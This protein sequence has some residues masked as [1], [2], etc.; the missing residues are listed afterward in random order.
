MNPALFDRIIALLMRKYHVVPLEHYLNDP[1][2]FTSHKKPATV[3]FDDGYKDN[4][5]VAA[6][7][8]KK[9]N[10][11]ASFYV[12]SECIDKNIPTWTY[13]VDNVFQQTKNKNLQLDFSY[14]P[15]QLKKISLEN[16]NNSPGAKAI[17]PWMKSLSNNRRVEIM[18]ALLDQCRDAPVPENKMMSWND[19]RQLDQDGFIIG[20]H[21]HTHPML[22]SLEAEQEIQDELSV[23]FSKIQTA[24]GKAPLS[25]SYPIG[26]FD[27]RVKRISQQT[28]YRYGLAVK[29]QFYNTTNND[30]FEIPRV[31]LYEEPWWKTKTRINGLYSLAKR[32]WR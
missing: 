5:Q 18:Q 27:Q 1:G 19:V 15:E 11:P 30:L 17:K 6:P 3:L 14:V 8:L 24:T 23:S 20:S 21:S 10:C 25:I 2:A 9:Y 32:I 7:I 4:S 22:A 16:G 12:V 13:I 29:Q 31:E 28:G 26:S